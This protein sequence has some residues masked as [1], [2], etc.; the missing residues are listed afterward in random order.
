ML[1]KDETYFTKKKRQLLRLL[2]TISSILAKILPQK[3]IQKRS[4]FFPRKF[5]HRTALQITEIAQQF[6]QDFWLNEKYGS[7]LLDGAWVEGGRPTWRCDGRRN[8]AT[9]LAA[10]SARTRYRISLHL[11]VSYSTW[12]LGFEKS[13]RFNGR[14]SLEYRLTVGNNAHGVEVRFY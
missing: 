14:G 6:R 11:C 4:F 9:G 10:S 3:F 13:S 5:S 8:M 2:K 12:S 1:Q 7:Y